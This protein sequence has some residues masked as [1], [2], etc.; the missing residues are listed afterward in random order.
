MISV[1]LDRDPLKFS[2]YS[3]SSEYCFNLFMLF[4]TAPPPQAISGGFDRRL[5]KQLHRNPFKISFVFQYMPTAMCWQFPRRYPTGLLIVVDWRNNI[6]RYCTGTSSKLPLYPKPE[7]KTTCV[8]F[9]FPEGVPGAFVWSIGQTTSRDAI[10][11][12]IQN[13]LCIPFPI[14]ANFCMVFNPLN[15]SNAPL[16]RCLARRWLAD[17]ARSE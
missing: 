5:E 15:V 7:Y 12:P 8:C 2:F 17:S 6:Q 3:N 14:Y 16:D 4:C 11:G 10:S 9:L 13:S 1:T